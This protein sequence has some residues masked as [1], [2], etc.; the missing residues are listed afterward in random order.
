MDETT[1]KTRGKMEAREPQKMIRSRKPR[2]V[3]VSIK[4][5]SDLPNTRVSNYTVSTDC[6]RNKPRRHYL[7]PAR[8]KF[9]CS[10]ARTVVVWLVKFANFFCS[11]R[12]LSPLPF[13]RLIKYKSTFLDANTLLTPNFRRERARNIN[14]D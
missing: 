1:T 2:K 13:H 3:N 9:V 5:A 11:P 4:Q 8:N 10:L 12:S 14:G 6:N 7:A